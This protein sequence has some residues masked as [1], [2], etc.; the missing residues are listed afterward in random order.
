MKIM[1]TVMRA[2]L[3]AAIAILLMGCSGVSVN[4]SITIPDGEKRAA[5]LNSVNGSITIGRDCEI[6]GECRTVNGRIKV[7]DD[8]RVSDLGTVNGGITLGREVT[9]AGDVDT[10]NGPVHCHSG[11]TVDGEVTTVNGD[12]RLENTRVEGNV[13]T[14]NG[15]IHLEAE[16]RVLGDLVVEDNKG[17]HSERGQLRI[18]ITD[19][20]VVSGD[21]IVRDEDLD[22]VVH[23]SGGGAV[24]GEVI[25]AKIAD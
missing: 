19:G 24:K 17:S 1:N 4:Q 6:G 14:Y 15:D 2:V 23:I 22:V 11:T 21:V 12:I 5:G 3:A 13:R 20:S 10:V 16:S 8:S 25:G 18:D 7:G 9:V